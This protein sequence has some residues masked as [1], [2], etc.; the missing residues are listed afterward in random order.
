MF[1]VALLSR[2]TVLHL[3]S[4]HTTW[5]QLENLGVTLKAHQ[6]FSVHTRTQESPVTLDLC[7]R[8]KNTHREITWSSRGHRFRNSAPFS[9]CFP[10]TR[11]RKTGVLKFSRFE[12]R[13]RKAP[14]SWR[15]SVHGRPNRRNRTCVLIV[16]PSVWL[17]YSQQ[18]CPAKNRAAMEQY[19]MFRHQA[20]CWQKIANFPKMLYCSNVSLS[21]EL[22]SNLLDVKL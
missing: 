17:F 12:E 11:K 16:S 19:P 18:E 21:A 6:M 20:S 10:F 3:V 2:L 1:N 5:E 4:V 14:F 15:I 7:L 13:F 8:S 22:S 9:K